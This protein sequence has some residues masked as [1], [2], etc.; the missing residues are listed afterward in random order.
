MNDNESTVE[1][2][3]HLSLRNVGQAALDFCSVNGNVVVV[4]GD[5][6]F[7]GISHVFHL[8]IL[9]ILLETC[10]IEIMVCRMLEVWLLAGLGHLYGE[11]GVLLR[12]LHQS[13]IQGRCAGHL[14][15][16]TD[17]HIAR[18]EHKDVARLV[19]HEEAAAVCGAYDAIHGIL[20]AVCIG[21]H[22]GN[23]RCAVGWGVAAAAAGRLKV[24]VGVVHHYHV[25]LFCVRKPSVEHVR[26]PAHRG[27]S[28]IGGC[29]LAFPCRAV[30]V[31][32][33]CH[34]ARQLVEVA[35]VF[36][37]SAVLIE[38]NLELGVNV[39]L[40]VF[41]LD[42]SRQELVGCDQ[43]AEI[44]RVL[45]FFQSVGVRCRTVGEALVEL[46]GESLV[47]RKVRY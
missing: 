34:F 4:A 18:L 13:A 7:A 22:V 27:W 32:G 42:E 21:N 14:H 36:R 15:L 17:F 10:S 9:H 37:L 35:E 16:V 41:V 20:A 2:C 43:R 33:E 12:E 46:G 29:R 26:H 39:S 23:L 44:L 45:E 24:G 47:C 40:R 3:I 19:G 30:V 28:E 38:C 11:F 6:E 1:A 25:A 31:G 8:R 5:G